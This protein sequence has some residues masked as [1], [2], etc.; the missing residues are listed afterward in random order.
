LHGG[1]TLQDLADAEPGNHGEGDQ[2]DGGSGDNLLARGAAEDHPK[3][4]S[5]KLAAETDD[6]APGGGEQQGSDLNDGKDSDD[7]QALTTN[8]AQDQGNQR[9]WN[10]EF[11]KTC[12]VIAVH[13][14]SEGNAAVAH[15]AKP[16]ELPVESEVLK[17]SEDGH[18][19]RENHHEPDE[20]LSNP[21][22]VRK[23]GR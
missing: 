13:V 16:V 10:G 23:P 1:K 4:N 5:G 14:G 21:R 6:A 12:K 7:K 19:E 17:N 20:V 9:Y 15:L 8:L 3:S 2:E 18:A 11:G 22:G